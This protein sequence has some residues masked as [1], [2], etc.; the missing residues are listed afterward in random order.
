MPLNPINGSDGGQLLLGTPGDDLIYGFD[1]DGPQANPMGITAQRF[2]PRFPLALDAVAPPEDPDRLFIVEKNGLIQ[3]VDLSQG[4]AAVFK[5]KPGPFLDVST[6]ITT[7]VER[8]LLGLAFDPDY[9]E[10]GYFYVNLTNT[11]GNSEIRRYHVSATDPDRADPASVQLILEVPQP[12]AGNHK[13]GWL[14]FGPDGYLYAAFGDG[15]STPTAAQDMDNLRGKILR[16]DVHDDGFPDDP[17]RNYAIPADNPFV[18]APGA[19]EIY[20]SG[21][22]NPWRDS[23]DRATGR[24]YIADV[25]ANRWEEVNLGVPGANYGW[26]IDEGPPGTTSPFTAPIYAYPHDA[27][28]QSITGGYVYRGQ[29]DFLHGQ[30]FFADYINV[31]FWTLSES[32]GAWSAADRT[33]QIST[34][35]GILNGPTSFGEDARGNLYIVQFNGEVFRLDPTG[36]SGDGDD[37][38]AAGIGHDR[39]F[40]GAGNDQVLGN[41]GND[42]VLGMAGNDSIG[43]GS[44]D[45]RIDGGAGN[46]TID[47]DSGADWLHGGAGIDIVRGGA[48]D[49]LIFGGIGNDQLTGGPGDDTTEGGPGDD[50]HFV[51]SAGDVVVER[52]TEGA[53]D[54]VFAAVSYTLPEGAEIENFSTNNHAGTAPIDLTGNALN[55]L[56]YGNAGNN[57][58]NG[59]GGN[60]TLL[61]RGGDDRMIGGTGNDWFHVD[62]AGDVALDRVGEGALDRIFAS[63]SYTLPADSEIEIFSTG[64]HAGTAPIDL[65]GNALPNVIYGNAGNNVLGG[66]EGNDTLVGLAGNDAFVFDTALDAAANVDRVAD[67]NI[68]NDTL[69]LDDV[70][71][72]ALAPGPLPSSAFGFGAEPQNPA[73]HVLYDG[74][75]GKVYYDADGLPGGAVPFASVTAG[76][77]LSE[78][79]FVVV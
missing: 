55:N 21:L 32:A 30:Y 13:A 35:A 79:N 10:N 45:D 2:G 65:T 53:G 29:S 71:F 26:P 14:D 42:A 5:A 7:D 57:T 33:P 59:E 1:P 54:R 52:A 20:A 16:L 50:W 47:G 38:I 6:E 27:R 41:E 23:F 9:R 3:I 51:D 66:R 24:F 49:D 62:D 76:L 46:D 74:A 37:I 39:V 34:S 68:A 44:G 18:N 22:R 31:T 43:G 60:D 69:R 56:I 4:D 72:T 73:Q 28:S 15:G 61:G 8:G 64:F 17:A 70:V 11:A 63:V 40:A 58:L 36:T 48:G 77:A 78:A 67:F 12:A 19:D 75:T 25:G